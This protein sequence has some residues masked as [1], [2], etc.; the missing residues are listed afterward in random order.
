[1]A[2]SGLACQL[3]GSSNAEAKANPLSGR[4]L[5]PQFQDCRNSLF[6]SFLASASQLVGVHFGGLPVRI[7]MFLWPGQVTLGLAA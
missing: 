6:V 5:G 2:R 7:L 3:C 4:N 1:M